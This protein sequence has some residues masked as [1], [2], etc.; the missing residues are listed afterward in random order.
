MLT[1]DRHLDL[2]SWVKDHEIRLLEALWKVKYY[3]DRVIHE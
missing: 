1:F 3:H 2:L